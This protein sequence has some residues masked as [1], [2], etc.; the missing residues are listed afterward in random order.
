MT[1]KLATLTNYKKAERNEAKKREAKL[2]AKISLF[3]EIF[4]AYALYNIYRLKLRRSTSI[5]IDFYA[6]LR[7]ALLFR[8]VWLFF[9]KF[10]LTTNW[11]FIYTG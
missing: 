10:F 2:G 7:F 9:T 4:A 5:F 6:K 8:F 11:S 1:K 3:I